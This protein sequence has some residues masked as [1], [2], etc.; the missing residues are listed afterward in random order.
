MSNRQIEIILSWSARFLQTQNARGLLSRAFVEKENSVYG[1]NEM[2][3]DLQVP[4]PPSWVQ[5]VTVTLIEWPA[6]L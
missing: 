1:V 4:P 2:G 5:R 6:G 3:M